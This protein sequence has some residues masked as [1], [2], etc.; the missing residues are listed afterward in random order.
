MIYRQTENNIPGVGTWIVTDSF[1]IK[2]RE[3][4]SPTPLPHHV[5]LRHARRV[6]ETFKFSQN[7]LFQ[8]N[9]FFFLFQENHSNS[10]LTLCK[11]DL[12]ILSNERLREVNK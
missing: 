10:F 9:E 2:G 4:S 1:Y 8:K 3:C 5:P 6:K 11:I 7:S 12:K